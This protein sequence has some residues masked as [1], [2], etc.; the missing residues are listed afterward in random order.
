M[1]DAKTKGRKDRSDIE[2]RR[3]EHR[4]KRSD[5]QQVRQVKTKLRTI[6]VAV[7]Q[8]SRQI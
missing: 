7:K 4:Q 5:G 6:E 2:A 3:K 1:R 8:K